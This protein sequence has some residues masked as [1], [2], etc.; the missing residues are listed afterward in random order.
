MALYN[1]PLVQPDHALR[2]VKTALQIRGALAD[3]HQQFDP[4]FRVKINFGIQTGM[5]VVGLVGTHDLMEFT[6][7]GDTVNLASRLQD[8]STNG[9]I[10]IGQSTYDQIE[11]HVYIDHVGEQYVKG[12]EEPVNVYEVLDLPT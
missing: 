6:A 1:T 12:R 10:L 8:L 9:Q 7:V 2:A 11:G 5:A 3:F 4:N